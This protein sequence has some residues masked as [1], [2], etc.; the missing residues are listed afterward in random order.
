MKKK[1]SSLNFSGTNV[2]VVGDVILDEYLMGE[3]R[4]LSPEAPVPIVHI[5][6]KTNTLGGSGNVALNLKSLGCTVNLF[7]IRGNDDG[8]EKLSEILSSNDIGDFLLI[9]QTK[10]TTRKTRIIGQGQQLLR[11]DEEEPW[12]ITNKD[13]DLLLTQFK[14]KIDEADAVILSDYNKGVLKG[15]LPQA[16]IKMCRSKNIPVLIDPKR[17]NWERYTG[18][19]YITPNLSEFEEITGKS[20]D[21]DRNKLIAEANLMRNK[22]L[23][24]RLVIT[25][26]AD[27]MCLVDADE[28]AYFI[29]SAAREVFDV[30]GA[31][32]TVI[33]VLTACIAAGKDFKESAEIAN[34]AAG[35]AVG[36]VGSQPVQ[37]RELETELRLIEL[38][39]KG[40]GNGKNHTL[41]SAEVKI[42]SWQANG[43]KIVFTYGSFDVLHSGHIHTL[44][45]AKNLG[46]RLIVGVRRD[47]SVKNKKGDKFPI[48][49]EQDR[50]DVLSALNFIDIIIPFEDDTPLRIIE[51]IKPHVIVK[52][53]DHK[54][55]EVAGK[56]FIE[57]YGGS[58]HLIPLLNRPAN[59]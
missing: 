44:H 49:H 3:V 42:K 53:S 41:N 45:E 51:M 33:A 16:I 36:K 28:G 27:G 4:R 59:S 31:G 47:N 2:F 58:V 56:N 54:L 20:I 40:I 34:T 7:G 30:T 9:D 17:M 39:A 11:L 57:S 1:Y 12:E 13:S 22:Y 5:K 24:E 48:L 10:P 6:T 26:G 38:G 18:A 55:E 37:L 50:I 32:D 21:G 23:F 35:I 46:D 14:N 25:L 29:K 19:A 15:G 52:G 8:G 43:E